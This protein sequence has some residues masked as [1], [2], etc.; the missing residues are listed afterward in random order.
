MYASQTIHISCRL[1][2]CSNRRSEENARLHVRWSCTKVLGSWSVA[3]VFFSR[4]LESEKEHHCKAVRAIGC[5]TTRRCHHHHHP[6]RWNLPCDTWLC[7]AL[8]KQPARVWYVLRLVREAGPGPK[9]MDVHKIGKAGALD[10]FD[11]PLLQLGPGSGSP[12]SYEKCLPIDY[13]LPRTSTSL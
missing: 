4:V 2:V 11:Q 10:F 9:P 13:N 6:P 3:P 7:R 8:P 1:Y 12:I 5:S